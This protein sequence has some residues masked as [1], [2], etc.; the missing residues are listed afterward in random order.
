MRNKTSLSLR[1]IG[2]WLATILLFLAAPASAGNSDAVAPPGT[3]GGWPNWRGPEHNGTTDNA[4][5][6]PENWGTD[7]NVRW[8]LKMPAWSGSTPI[9]WEDRVFLLSPSKPEKPLP[10]GERGPGGQDILLYCVSRTNGEVLWRRPVDRGNWLRMKHNSSSPSPVTDGRH[11][12]AVSGN[13]HVAAFDIDGTPQWTF[14]IEEHF[15]PIGTNFGYG[16]SPLLL[17]GRLVFQVLQGARTDDPSY[18]FALD[19]QSGDLLWRVERP[20]EAR[21]ESPDAYTTPAFVEHDGKKQIV[22]LG[23]D[24]VTGHDSETGRELWRSGGL[25]PR[26][27]RDYRIIPSPIVGDGMIFAPTR[28]VPLLALRAGGSGDITDSHLVWSWTSRGAPDVPTPALHDGLFY[29]IEDFGRITCVDALTGEAIYGP[30]ELGLGRVSSSP[31]VADE[32]IYVVNES[33]ETAV[34]AAGRDF[35]LLARNALDDSYTLSS[36]VAAGTDLFIR[37]GSYLYCLSE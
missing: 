36:P 15:G 19:A 20:T 32:K 9:I 35:K 18:V 30:E 12:W 29:M 7:Q 21:N 5:N 14:S 22:V 1:S 25:N 26:N 28:Q 24:H 8:K 2:F 10:A 4:S 17:D 6:L 34:V 16:S 27:A 23:G 31:L 33:G 37:T 13:G 3:V 11:V